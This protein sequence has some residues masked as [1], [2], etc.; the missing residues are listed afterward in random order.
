MKKNI[1]CL[2]FTW[3]FAATQISFAQDS[4]SPPAKTYRIAVFAP[5]YLDS[6]FNNDLLNSDK[7][8]PKFIMP[9]IEFTQGAR[10]ALDTLS[11]NGKHA[12]AYI[13]DSKS[14]TQPIPWLIKYKKLDSIDLI[15]GSVKDPDYHELA[16]FALQKK[17]PFI[18]ATYP[19]DGGITGNPFLVIANST[20]K[21]N[22]EGIFSYLLQNHGTDKIYI[23]KRK[24]D[25]RIENYFRSINTAEGKPLLNIKTIMIDSSISSYSLLNRIDTN[26]LAV[27]IGA[28]L[29]EGFARNLADA[30]YLVQKK[31]SLILIGMPNWD[32]FKSLTKTDH[33]KD[34]PI[35]YTTPHFDAANNSFD[36]LL[37]QKYFQLY[38]AKPTDMAYKGFEMTYYF[39][40][41]L[42]N[43]PDSFMSHINDT[44]FIVF[45]DFNFRPVSVDKKNLLPDYFENKHL[46]IMQIL[47]GDI[48]REW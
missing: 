9:A 42:L 12:E 29:D 30:C 5:M 33:Y 45:H 7:S 19:N 32:G 23:V 40:N 44:S 39:T 21:A 8:M 25:D 15:I 6:V 47:N 37:I 38:R 20:L 4:F 48:A 17:I 34:F 27:I 16:A 13:Y 18:S 31:H 14:F 2:A 26:R 35:R 11:L 24:G 28:G 46:F 22:C 43:Y 1:W 3:F 36:S 10:I 41:I